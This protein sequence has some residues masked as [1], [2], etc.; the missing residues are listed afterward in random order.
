MKQRKALPFSTLA[1]IGI[2]GGLAL[3]ITLVLIDKLSPDA[4]AGRP[5]FAL[6][7][8]T[9]G[10]GD[11]L[12]FRVITDAPRSTA[13]VAS[14]LLMERGQEQELPAWWNRHGSIY[15]SA[16]ELAHW[17][18]MPVLALTEKARL[19]MQRNP[20]KRRAV[21]IT[22]GHLEVRTMDSGPITLAA[23]HPIRSSP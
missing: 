23:L 16:A 2:I 4:P 19:R 12:E 17:T 21:L 14:L 20:E 1:L 15:S 18:P 10:F 8:E 9:R 7:I 22:P 13:L 6:S 5:A 3:S 11:S